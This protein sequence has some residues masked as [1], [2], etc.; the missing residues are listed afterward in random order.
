MRYLLH[1]SAIALGA[2]V[3]TTNPISAQDLY[4]SVGERWA[5]G[6]NFEQIGDFDSAISEYRDALNQNISI[7]NPTLRD[8]ARQGTIARLEGATAG[9]HYIQSYGNSPDSVKAAQQASQDQFRQAMDAF[10]KS[11]PDLANSCP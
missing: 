6:A 9:Q 7:T 1:Y 3:I 10:D 4:G 11:R 2:L 5:N 8:C